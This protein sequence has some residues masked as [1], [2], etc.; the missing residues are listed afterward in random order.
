[1][2]IPES[3]LIVEDEFIVANDLQIMLDRAGYNIVGIAPTVVEAKELIEL[4]KPDWVLLDIFLQDESMGTDLA[5]YLNELGIGFIYISANTNQSILS[6]AKAT[7]PYGFLVKPFREKDLLIMLDIAKDKR[8]NARHFSQQRELMLQIQLKNITDGKLSYQEYLKKLS[9]VFQ[10][11]IS[12]DLL[13]ISYH[14]PGKKRGE[15]F[16]MIRIGFDEY[17]VLTYDQVC[18]RTRQKSLPLPAYDGRDSRVF[19]GTDFEIEVAKDK[20]EA[21]MRENFGVQSKIRYITGT[22]EIEITLGFYSKIAEQYTKDQLITLS[23]NQSVI[24][25]AISFLAHLNQVSLSALPQRRAIRKEAIISDKK[26]QNIIGNSP[27]LLSV[28]DQIEMVAPTPVSVLVLGESGTGKEAIARS[29][30]NLSPRAAKPF[31]TVNCATLPSELIE[32]ELF[33]HEK[34]SFTGASE[35]R[36]G[37]FELADGGTIYLDEIGEIPL[38]L[39]VKLLRVLQEKEFE[40]IGSSQTIKSDVRVI[41]VTNRDLE[42]EVAE[43]RFR[44][45]LFYRLNVFPI[46]LPSLRE[47]LEDIPSLTQ[48]FLEK[49]CREIERGSVPTISQEAMSSLKN[50]T[51]PGNIRELKHLVERTLIRCKG[52]IIEDFSLPS[53]GQ[54]TKEPT[55]GVKQEK[56]KTLEEMETDHIIAVLKSCSG[57]VAGPGGA[58]DMLGLPSSTLTSKIKKLGIKREFYFDK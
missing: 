32:S 14:T 8:A 29:I 40:R 7:Q 55:S 13:T 20:Y 36:M 1:M 57:R 27:E 16:F 43:H 23:P 42:K 9:Q 25:K 51:W 37:K 24:C 47:R 45:D 4:H 35:R 2:N 26:F 38:E 3:V 10:T 48:H 19:T 18:V 58:A 34:G 52:E 56:Y 31:I 54:L 41:A 30:H 53:S 28:L 50:Y 33:G 46:E 39:Q 15:N 17:Q 6:R 11:S 22:Q 12:F 49:I 44:L 21:F 5:E